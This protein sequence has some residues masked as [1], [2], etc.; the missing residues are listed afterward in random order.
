MSRRVKGSFRAACAALL[1]GGAAVPAT[2][3]VLAAP[4]T[5]ALKVCADPH[6]LPFSNREEQGFENAI[7][8][9]MA[10]QLGLPLKYD[11]FPQ[12]RGFIRNTLK[13][14]LR[15]GV[16]KCDL[17]I[18][19]SRKFEQA[20]TTRPYYYS[21]YV[22]VFAAGRDLDKITSA[23]QLG[24][25]DQAT[26]EKIR[27]GVFDTGPG[28]LWIFRQGL[29]DYAVPYVGQP[30]HEK[31]SLGDILDDILTDKLDAAVAWGPF[32]GYY[33]KKKSRPGQL[34]FLPL[35]SDPSDPGMRFHFGISMAVRYGEKEWKQRVNDLITENLDEI[36]TI[37]D[38]YGVPRAQVE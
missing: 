15:D 5:K 35:T 10:K 21:T 24:Q 6:N 38:E 3:P 22:L 31:D 8:R 18:G 2:A 17:V 7:A 29:M 30:G 19:V 26:R 1:V 33:A 25:V 11:W 36:H 20:A 4:D 14:E 12:R 32:A 37:L 34:K 28:Q 16:Y 27:I 9:L 23:E 13:S